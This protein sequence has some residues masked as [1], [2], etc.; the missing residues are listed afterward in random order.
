[1]SPRSRTR[2]AVTLSAEAARRI[3]VDRQGFARAAPFGRGAPALPRAVAHLGHVQIDSISV[4]VRA[5]HH[6]LHARIPDHVPEHL[7][8]ALN[9][10]LFEYWAHAAAFLPLDRYRFALPL[11]EAHRRRAVRWVR[12]RDPALEGRLL[13]QVRE[14]G[15]C[16][17]RDFDAPPGHRGAG[18]WNWKP[19][20]R[21]L[22]HLFMSG[23]LMVAARTGLEK[24]YDLPE[25][26]LPG[27]V[28]TRTPDAQALARHVA[29]EHLRAQGV[30]QRA[31]L[32][33]ARPL[34]GFTA[35]MDAAL[36]DLVAEGAVVPLVP[37]PDRQAPEPG[38]GWYGDPA[39][40]AAPPE[41][42]RRVLRILS[43]FDNLVIDR[44]RLQ[45]LFGY[46]YRLECYLP[47][48][49]RIF[50]Y[51]CLPLLLG[52]RFV[53][54]LDARA[55]RTS[56]MLEVRGLHLESNAPAELPGLEAAL[57]AL[58]RASGC[59]SVTPLPS[60]RGPRRLVRRRT[61]P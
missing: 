1:M 40:L 18:W 2:S 50:G 5:H 34:P 39:A 8:R 32:A 22:E 57:E 31:A 16:R 51:F 49:R 4:V 24:V 6:V 21:A 47:P 9:R 13:A 35:R 53:G 42:I 37:K 7:D 30:V 52:T 54:R 26:V 56:G 33:S 61:R 60:P 45:R 20:K 29:L 12:S 48:A 28:D 46:D 41:R 17:A 59:A 11:M 58:A 55:D 10:D 38:T 27:N 19:A 3:V 25:R 14:R 44:L 23:A 36:A 15:P 43:P